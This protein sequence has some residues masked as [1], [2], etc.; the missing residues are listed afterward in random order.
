MGR[1]ERDNPNRDYDV[2]K[3]VDDYIESTG[4]KVETPPIPEHTCAGDKCWC[5]QF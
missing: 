3:A 1:R 5:T 2:D 4:G